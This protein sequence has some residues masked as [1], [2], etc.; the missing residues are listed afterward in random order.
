ML[1]KPD[2]KRDRKRWR[3]QIERP[4]AERLEVHWRRKSK[5]RIKRGIV[6]RIPQTMAA[7]LEAI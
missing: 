3:S 5:R 7:L 1:P 2:T 4:A 6:R